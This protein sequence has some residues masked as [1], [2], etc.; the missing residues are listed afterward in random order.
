MSL[1]CGGPHFPLV[2]AMS[3]SLRLIL[4]ASVAVLA[5]SPA[6][7]SKD[8]PAA[9]L[10]KI[11]DGRVA[12]KPQRCVDLPQV[13]NTQIID[14]TT[15]AY[16][17]GPTWYVNQLRSGAPSLDRDDV[18]M[19]T[20]TFGAQLCELDNVKLIDRFA[21]GLRGFVILGPFIP[22]TAPAKDR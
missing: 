11:T 15:I 20:D 1:N 17:I 2:T 8:D 21:G 5:A 10:A 16:R 6:W 18:I 22:Y 14:K 9:A 7:A 12:G 19:V 13:S 3:P 4:S